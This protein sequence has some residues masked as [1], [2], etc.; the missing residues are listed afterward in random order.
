VPDLEIETADVEPHHLALDGVAIADED[1]GG[2]EL[3]HRRDGALDDHGGAMIAPH[4]VDRD[5]Q[6]ATF[7]R[8]DLATLVVPAVRAHAVWQLRLSALRAHGTRGIVELVVRAALASAR[9]G[10]AS[11]RQR[12][13][14][15][16]RA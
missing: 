12:H 8:D 3:P 1:D 9:L 11:F 10:V 15:F 14:V 2:A 4:G 13:G 16:L 5:L 6:L 7:G